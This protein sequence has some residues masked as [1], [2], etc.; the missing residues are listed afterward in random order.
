ML[1]ADASPLLPQVD[2]CLVTHFHLDHC[3]ALP[4]LL[5]HTPF[6]GRVLMTH[7][8][9]AIYLMLLSDFCRLNKG[10]ADDALFTEADLTASLGRIECV[11]FDQTVDVGGIKVTPYRAGH[12]LGAAMFMVDIAGLRTLYTGDYSRKADRHLPGADLPGVAPH[13]LIVESTYGVST[14][15][16]KEEREKRFTDRVA[17]TVRRGGKVLLPIVALGR[18]QELLL[19]LDDYWAKHPDLRHVPVFQASGLAKRSLSVYQTYIGMLNEDM[20]KAWDTSTPFVLRHVKHL[21]HGGRELDAGGPCVVLATPSMLQS[22]LSREL[23]EAWCGDARNTVII[24]DFAVAGTLARDILADATEVTSRTGAVLP[25][26][27][28]VDAISFSAH[29]DFPQ[30]SG[31]VSALAPRHVVLVHGEAVEMQ[32][33]KRALEAQA[34]TEGRAPFHVYTPR[35]CQPVAIHHKGDKVARIL[36]RLAERAVPGQ[37]LS[38]VLVRKEWG[39]VMVDPADLGTFTTLKAGSLRQ[40]QLVPC[41]AAFPSVRLALEA[42]FEGVIYMRTEPRS[43]QRAQPG[44]EAMPPVKAEETEDAAPLAATAGT[45]DAEAGDGVS[46]GGHVTVSPGTAPG[47]PHVVLEWTSDPIA[48]MVADATLACILQLEG[49]PQGVTD[50]EEAHAAAV[51]T[52]QEAAAQWT[53]F[54]AILGAQFGEAVVDVD[55]AEIRLCGDGQRGEAGVT[56]HLRTGRVEC[57]D[58]A[59]QQR[60]ERAMHRIGCAI[61]PIRLPAPTHAAGDVYLARQ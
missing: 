54:G 53:L 9:K 5:A 14:H 31:F 56:V 29:A 11:D 36:G 7:A 55:K 49:P 15:S 18:A 24:A 20:Q 8:T 19:I 35:N 44:E 34:E 12:V 48:D 43:P 16:P 13:V 6:R 45:A 17:G 57:E 33:L 27:C 42:L 4:F 60:V 25:I 3:A 26:K 32:R 21:T 23:F 37:P 28:G 10:T 51:G 47:A 50:A 22:G 46:V 61:Q 59:R 40:R 1:P 38:G 39:H 30:T 41:A 52:P 2:V 58:A